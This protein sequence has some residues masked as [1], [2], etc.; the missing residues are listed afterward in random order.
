MK[1]DKAAVNLHSTAA[2]RLLVVS[3]FAG[4]EL[5][6]WEQSVRPIALQS[7]ALS[8]EVRII[9]VTSSIVQFEIITYLNL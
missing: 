5:R 1:Q 2:V 6:D 3:V 8:A 7:T 4:P 9:L